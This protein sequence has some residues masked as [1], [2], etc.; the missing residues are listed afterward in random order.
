MIDKIKYRIDLI[1]KQL[2]YYFGFT[3]ERIP[4]ADHL[5]HFHKEVQMYELK[6]LA[7]DIKKTGNQKLYNNILKKYVAEWDNNFI[8]SEFIGHGSGEH[9]LSVYRK[10]CFENNYYFE[11]VYFN[12]SY[13]LIK[14]E[15][16]YEYIYPLLNESLNT[17]KLHQ[18]IKGD[19][20]TI[21]YFE[22]I[23]LVPLSK[24]A[25]HLNYID[26]SKK[27]FK[28]SKDNEEI[29]KNAPDFFK[30]YR[31]HYHYIT[32]IETAEEGIKK[33]S[34]NRLTIKMIEQIID[35]QPLIITH[36]DVYHTNIFVDNYIIDWDS[37]GLF[38][39][40][41][42]VGFIFA[43]NIEYLT[44]KRLQELLNEEYKEIISKDEW[45]GFELSCWYFYLI[46]TAQDA[47]I[48]S[49]ETWQNE[50]FNELERLYNKIII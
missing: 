18:I 33:L 29:I 27:M 5:A 20:I 34:N 28:I 41:F 12:D 30:N 4:D 6:K 37:F 39:H 16:F 43:T 13:D 17:V 44:F 40:G 19:I 22:Y 10:V 46:L 38:P 26:I 2:F 21:V 50:A 11:K 49:Y 9:N 47:K 31:L 8:S 7:Y 48:V 35:L 42:E 1:I 36:G 14:V 3:I 24:D 23:N 25:F 45:D 15:W 32:S